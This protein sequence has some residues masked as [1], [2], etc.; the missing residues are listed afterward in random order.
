[1]FR[2]GGPR[3]RGAERSAVEEQDTATAAAAAAALLELEPRE[4]TGWTED[5]FIP[6]WTW[7]KGGERIYSDVRMDVQHTV[8]FATTLV[9][10][11]YV[12]LFPRVCDF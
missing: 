10:I 9:R 3:R 7:K 11:F 12:A 1:M 8:Q 6:R 5:S 4:E 2:E